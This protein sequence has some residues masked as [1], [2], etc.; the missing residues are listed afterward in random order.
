MEAYAGIAELYDQ[1]HDQFADDVEW[2]T[3]LAQVAGPRVLELGC[4]SGR[5][6]APLAT[7]GNHVT[8]VDSSAAM[9]RRAEKR[10]Q[11]AIGRKQAFL[12]HGNMEELS[13]LV[14]GPFDLVIIPLNG[15]LHVD[16]GESQRRVLQ[17]AAEVLRPGGLLAVDVLHAV[18]DALAMYDGRVVLEGTWEDGASV[19]SKFSSRTTDWT[20]QR[21]ESEIWYDIAGHD[22]T[23]K[24]H[25]TA[26][27]MRWLTP[28]E[29]ALMLELTG[30]EGWNLAGNYDGSPLTDLSDRLLV[31][32]RNDEGN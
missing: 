6:M 18:P 30:F 17:Q 2:Y 1:E 7:A 28:S 9:L 32:A 19:I 22:G 14:P 24:R 13:K 12:V 21:I 26:F 20:L 4:G 3:H 15:L 5:L 8:G 27:P 16:E 10:L 31:V 25:R 23:V 11:E 29:V